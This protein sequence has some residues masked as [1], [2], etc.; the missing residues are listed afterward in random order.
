MM[1]LTPQLFLVAARFLYHFTVTNSTVSLTTCIH[2][3]LNSV[4]WLEIFCSPA[5]PPPASSTGMDFFGSSSASDSI[6]SL[7]LVP[8]ATYSTSSEAA[9]PTSSSFDAKFMAPPPAS[10][11]LSQVRL[12]LEQASQNICIG[13]IDQ[14]PSIFPDFCLAPTFPLELLKVRI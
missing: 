5:A 8:V 4:C 12:M 11:V 13:W 7:A 3:M 6:S 2:Y 1:W 10:A 9:A 14:V